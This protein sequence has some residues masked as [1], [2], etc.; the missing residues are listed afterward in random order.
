MGEVYLARDTQSG[1]NV[2][3]KRLAEKFRDDDRYRQRL[4][5]EARRVSRLSNEHVAAIHESVEQNAEVFLVME[6]VDGITLRERMRDA[7]ALD[8]SL[9]I[10][11]QCA[12]GL[13]AAH[14]QGI[15]HHDIKPENIMLSGDAGTVK[16]CDFGVARRLPDFFRGTFMSDVEDEAHGGTLRYM[17]PETILD[18]APDGRADIFSLGVVLYEA[19]TR[20]SPFL[21]ASPSAVQARILD[22]E[23]APVRRLNP[24]VPVDLERV[25]TRML[26][27]D[28][29]ARYSSAAD[30]LKEL[31]DVAGTL[32]SAEEQPTE[33]IVPKY[34][35]ATPPVVPRKTLI[36]VALLLPA[37]L[38]PTTAG[39]PIPDLPREKSLMV[40][41]F[42]TRGGD[43]T[44]QAFCDGLTQTLTARLSRL[45]T[46]RALQVVPQVDVTA[47]QT[48]SGVNLVLRGLC[49]RRGDDVRV[50][51]TL[52]DA[53][54]GR[55]LRADSTID[56]ATASVAIQ[57]RVIDGAMR[58]LGIDPSVATDHAT[59]T[60][61][62][63]AMAEYLLGRGALLEYGKPGNVGLAIEAF[64]RA[65]AIDPAFAAAY[66]ELGAAYVKQFELTRNM[67]WIESSR[68][69]CGRAVELDS[70]LSEAHICLGD[71]HNRT[72]RYE[73]AI[74]EFRLALTTE[75]T[76]DDAYRGLAYALEQLRKPGDAETTYREAIRLRP[77]YWAGYGWLASFLFRQ[78][79][80]PEAAEQYTFALSLSRDNV[81]L[82]QSRGAIYVLMGRY[83][84]GI[85]DL[86]RAN[87][88]QPTAEGFTNLGVTYFSVRMFPE[89]VAALEN[90]T[91][92]A[93]SDFSTLASLGDA[94][95]YA[96]GMRPQA[97]RIYRQALSL[98]DKELVANPR[99]GWV[100][101]R[102]A[103]V[104]AMLGNRD[105]AHEHVRQGTA[106]AADDNETAFFAAVTHARLG[107][108][109]RA[110]E[111]L[112]RAAA[113]GYSRAEIRMRVDFDQLRRDPRFSA[114]ITSK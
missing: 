46:G 43:L 25:V 14:T 85:A 79:R 26:A 58:M 83:E 48:A 75:P 9:R 5:H 3:L 95:Y 102:M 99:N 2:A 78:G 47:H 40:L 71:L 10:I 28:P 62:P 103:S 41:R 6:Y 36:A 105:A 94:Y 18:K 22:H 39:Y 106:I 70:R 113:M 74:G 8:D 98:G 108:Q 92:R 7:L 42:R 49:E 96:P 69:A 88:L 45:T 112:Q 104:H 12:Q 72:G 30:L 11:I 15:V 57:N 64:T 53:A 82:L 24:Q 52:D 67:S 54:S 56:A 68:K 32:R 37:V 77:A 29:S 23:P 65:L 76:S 89:A 17:A 111:W 44:H 109:D 1:R 51:Y 59:R 80:Y 20:Q 50:T 73:E 38:L 33:P 21:A 87:A 16:I 86:E 27:K 114:L 100:H 35:R 34:P 63:A 31:L 60:P 101:V 61:K 97:D 90:A 84:E 66:A 81:R 110:L 93:P 4:A 107:D 19:L 55:Q 91:R 13:A